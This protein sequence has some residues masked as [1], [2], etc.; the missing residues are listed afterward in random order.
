MSNLRA[1]SWLTLL[2]RGLIAIAFGIFAMVNSSATALLLFIA[3]VLYTVADGIFTL[4]M[5]TVH[6]RESP[7]WRLGVL[8]GLMSIL[9]GLVALM[10]PKI[11]ALLVLYIIS[12]R[13]IIGGFFEIGLALKLGKH[14]KGEELMIA[15]G[16]LS[17]FFGVWMFLQPLIGGLAVLW[18]IGLYAVMVG[19]LLV[20]QAFRVKM[21]KTQ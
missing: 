21:G 13:V 9:F 12:T 8:Y 11:T 10:A 3:F 1:G 2:L 7:R 18:V 14:V 16:A 15:A 17:V 4:V 20:I 19:A 6:R 5:A